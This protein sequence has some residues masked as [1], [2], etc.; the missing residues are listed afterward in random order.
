M[1]RY[2]IHFFLAGLMMAGTVALAG[3]AHATRA[4]QPSLVLERTI[5][6]A[7]VKGR[8]D[9]LAL[10]LTHHRL[11]VAEIANGSVDAVA[12]D[13]GS[14][15]GGAVAGR[16]TE[17]SEPQGLVYLPQG[18]ELVVACGG[19]GS[20]RFYDASTLTLKRK[21]D[22]FDDADDIR[23]DPSNGHV[24]I[25]FGAGGLVIIDPASY[26]VIGKI[27]L[28]SHPEGFEIA[29]DGKIAFVNLPRSLSIAVVD[30]SKGQQV[31]SWS[32]RTVLENFPMAINTAEHL[33]AVGFR[34]PG[35]FVT[36]DDRTGG[37]TS[38]LS[39]CGQT[40]DLFYDAKRQR[41]YMLC[42]TGSIDIF[43][44]RKG[45]IARLDDFSTGGRSRTGLFSS[46]ADRLYV[47]VSAATQTPAHV[48]VIAPQ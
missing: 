45:Q 23:I 26:S 5:P 17:L 38:S 25:G 18:N 8:I 16:I 44:K 47:A 37:I 36:F 2:A 12:L 11:F 1:A 46:E 33:I 24:V 30:M 34:L 31:S 14:G 15:E 22:G 28:P 48:L 32:T 21:L 19:D 39:G 6:L 9:H 43:G 7:D 4:A 20:I 3:C 35:R 41:Y 40:D 42:G 10:D 13:A 29:P 27:A